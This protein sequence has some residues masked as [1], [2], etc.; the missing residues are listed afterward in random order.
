[1][2]HDAAMTITALCNIHRDKKKRSKPFAVADFLP[3]MQ[4][5]Q[6]DSVNDVLFGSLREMTD[7]G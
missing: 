2:S 7:D 5:A 6:D 1:M 4:E 3:G